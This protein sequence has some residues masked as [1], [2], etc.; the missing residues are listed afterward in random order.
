MVDIGC[1]AVP[2][3]TDRINDFLVSNGLNNASN[4]CVSPDFCL[5]W[6]G[7]AY[8]LGSSEVEKLLKI[9]PLSKF[10]TASGEWV[11][12][13]EETTGEHAWLLK[14]SSASSGST[15]RQKTTASTLIEGIALNSQN[16]THAYPCS[17]INLL[18]MKNE[19]QENDPESTIFPTAAGTLEYQSLGIGARM[20]AMHWPAVDWTMAKLGPFFVRPQTPRHI[21]CARLEFNFVFSVLL[22]P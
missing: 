16:Y 22:I 13:E 19:V 6:A 8:K 15:K 17:L 21:S 3:A 1:A 2:I 12:G 7:L 14:A 18:K 11:L 5:N 10:T 9:Y 4:P 20:T